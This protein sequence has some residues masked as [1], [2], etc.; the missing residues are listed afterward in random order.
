MSTALEAGEGRIGDADC[1]TYFG[2]RQSVASGLNCGSK[3][4]CW[5]GWVAGHEIFLHA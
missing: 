5:S 4:S 2:L 3:G 1:R